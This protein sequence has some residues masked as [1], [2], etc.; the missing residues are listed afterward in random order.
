MSDFNNI[1]LDLKRKLYKPV[2]FLQ[3][4]EP[5]YIDEISHYIEHHV[6][7]ETER[8]FNQTVLYGRDTDLYSIV[9]LAK[10][11]PMIGERQVV[12]IKEAQEIKELS[13]STE[14]G[15][16]TK[17]KKKE[18]G[19]A[20]LQEYLD[21]PQPST[22]LVFCFKYGK[23]DARSSLA[24]ALAKK[25][26]LFES[27]KIYDDKVPNW[28]SSFLKEKKYTISPGAALVLA[29]FLGSDLSKIANELGKLFI[30][31]PQGSEISLDQIEQNIG[32]SK[33]FNAFELQNALGKKEVLKANRIIQHLSA[34]PKQT[35]LL[36]IIPLLYS[37]FQKILIY[38]YLPNKSN[39]ASALGI[40]PFF[41][42]GYETASRN[43][44][45]IKLKNIFSDLRIADARAKGID[46]A[47]IS[48]EDILKE[49]VYKILH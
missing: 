32:I 45:M 46:N 19:K 33:D 44:S 34:N 24:K 43:Y 25:A 22:I 20:L 42:S 48:D 27:K 2:Y 38:H 29:E 47:S 35:P 15:T 28:I 21:N 6:L 7:D 3:G 37:Y 5:Y 10:G 39:A 40:N 31:L 41:V 17:D 13:K 26:V 23:I 4:E 14:G 12:I 1:V 30:S 16:D 8:G 11:F 18:S 9:G 36:L 49:L